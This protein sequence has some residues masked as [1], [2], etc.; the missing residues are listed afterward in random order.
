MAKCKNCR[1]LIDAVNISSDG[2]SEYKWCPVNDDCPDVELKRECDYYEVM[3]QADRIRCMTDE[4][5]AEMLGALAEPLCD[6]RQC[7]AR[8]KCDSLASATDNCKEIFAKWL[9]SPVEV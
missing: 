6:C 9:Q 3:S 7:P 4:E 5:L 8:D 2:E 1:K